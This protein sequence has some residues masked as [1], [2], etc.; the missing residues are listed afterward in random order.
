M[1]NIFIACLQEAD[2]TKVQKAFDE[3]DKAARWLSQKINECVCRHTRM[4]AAEI[5]P[6]LVSAAETADD[7][8]HPYEVRRCN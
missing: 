7:W 8:N 1:H 6:V 2:G 5:R 3:R 4:K